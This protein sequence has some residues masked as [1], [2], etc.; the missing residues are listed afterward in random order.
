MERNLRVLAKSQSH[1]QF[2]GREYSVNRL[3]VRPAL[4]C[5]RAY[6]LLRHRFGIDPVANSQSL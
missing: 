1:R 2:R 6:K 5:T 4:G 3:G